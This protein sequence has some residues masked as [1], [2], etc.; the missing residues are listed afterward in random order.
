MVRVVKAPPSPVIY[1]D[2]L[3]TPE[4]A[5]EL[6]NTMNINTRNKRNGNINKWSR[7]MQRPG[8]WRS[9]NGVTVK[10]TPDGELIDGKNRMHAVIKANVHVVMPFAYNVP[11]DAMPTI[12]TGAAR[13]FA[14]NLKLRGEKYSAVGAAVTRRVYLW[15][16]GFRM[17]AGGSQQPSMMEL[18][19]VFDKKRSEICYASARGDDLRKST[20]YLRAATAGFLF[21]MIA[22]CDKGKAYDAANIFFD[23]FQ[24]GADISSGNPIWVLRKRL[25][26]L[27][28][29][30][31][32]DPERLALAINAWNFWRDDATIDALYKVYAANGKAS[33][34]PLSNEN[35]PVPR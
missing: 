35:F 33:T 1:K 23:K 8:G 16:N 20:G 2:V 15:N 4:M 32:S 13:T 17:G 30:Q 5:Q 31:L 14:D 28:A 22:G 34:T 19:A 12:D 26:R 18:D 3:V 6:L 27:D 24:D 10:V 21:Y 29:E 9:D 25:N 11:K 7:D